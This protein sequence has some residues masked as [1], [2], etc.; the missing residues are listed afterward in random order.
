MV[1]VQFLVSFRTFT[2]II[3]H[4]NPNPA[5]AP[6]RLTNQCSPIA[7]AGSNTSHRKETKRVCCCGPRLLGSQCQLAD[8]LT[9]LML[10]FV[11]KYCEFKQINK[12]FWTCYVGPRIKL[13][14]ILSEC[15][16]KTDPWNLA[17]NGS[18]SAQRHLGELKNSKQFQNKVQVVQNGSSPLS[19]SNVWSQLNGDIYSGAL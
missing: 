1:R 19:S 18:N 14:E 11:R 3:R 2:L 13:M 6:P 7:K 8:M 9:K 16:M 10:H 12:S 17:P 15:C 4:L 5:A